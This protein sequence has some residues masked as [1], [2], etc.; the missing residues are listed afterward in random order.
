ME[1]M[2]L[3]GGH[4]FVGRHIRAAWGG[5]VTLMGRGVTAGGE[6]AMAELLREAKPSVVVNAAGA[7][8]GA[9]EEAMELSN[10][11]LVEQL[12]AALAAVGGRTP[13]LVQ[14][15]T[16]HEHAAV[17]DYGRTKL[18][19]TQAVLAATR[20]GLVSGMVLRLSNVVG[21]GLSELSLPGATAARLRAAQGTGRPA[22]LHLV[23]RPERRDFIDVR[24]VTDA[25]LAAAGSDA[26][27]VVDICRGESVG[28]Q[29]VL[30]I[31]VAI[32]GVPTEIVTDSG[33]G[34][35][36]RGAAHTHEYDI[37]A[38]RELL[39]WRPRR[40]LADMLGDLWQAAV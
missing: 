35:P 26:E 4:G 7:V 9:D 14:L 34:Y 6:R 8:W 20:Q 24:D 25:V 22:E 32:S 37:T 3:L 18:R 17:S 31:L 30:D 5:E 36:A 39:G 40:G 12:L 29:A 28:I 11:V 15:G 21:P 10:A 33:A 23:A 38:A 13:R 27:G 2:V 1:H 16:V 19:A